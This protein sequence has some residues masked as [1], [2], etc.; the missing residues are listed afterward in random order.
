LVCWRIISLLASF[1]G[2]GPD[3]LIIFAHQYLLWKWGDTKSAYCDISTLIFDLRSDTSESRRAF[4]CGGGPMAVHTKQQKIAQRAY[5]LYA[6]RGYSDGY[7]L[8]DWLT[9]EAEVGSK[10]P[11]AS[12]GAK[13]STAR[14]RAS[15]GAKT[16][17]NSKKKKGH[18]RLRAGR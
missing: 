14:P 8:D 11:R 13:R 10:S 15:N 7:D 12:T 5:E 3:R 1:R 17:T 9:A 16:K 2:F 6:S 4:S 18:A